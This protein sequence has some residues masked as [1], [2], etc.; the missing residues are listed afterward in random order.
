[1]FSITET[2][3]R[4]AILVP[5]YFEPSVEETQVRS[6]LENTFAEHSLFC[7]Q[8]NTLAVVDAGTVAESVLK[9]SSRRSRLYGIPLCCLEKNHGKTGAVREGLRQLL[10][11]SG[12]EFFLSRDCDGD[13]LLTDLPRVVSMADRMEKILAHETVTIFGTR[14]SL[15]KPM[16]W[17]RQ[18]WE[19]LTNSVT[20]DLTEFV[21]SRRN[22]RILDRRFWNGYPLDLQSGYR[23]YSRAAAELAVDSLTV[24]PDERNVYLMA[25]EMMPFPEISVSGGVVG[26]VQRATMV[27]QPVS[28]YSQVPFAR[29]YADLFLFIAEHYQIPESVLL[30]SFDNHLVSSQAFFSDL[31]EELLQCR[32]RI[33]PDAPSVQLPS[34]L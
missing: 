24:L 20:V 30:S 6:I 4:V 10:A 33:S 18:Q 22:G 17:K 29:V 7:D 34:L 16:N 23:L 8:E 11:Q 3:Q 5:V 25:C 28:S 15:E 27:E 21:V 14:P 1:V 31:R 19:V 2:R 32:H 12:A 9:N 13:H 26:Q